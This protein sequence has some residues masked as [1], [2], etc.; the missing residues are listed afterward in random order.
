M[1]Q[2]E[3][4]STAPM[5]G[6]HNKSVELSAAKLGLL[7][8]LIGAAAIAL[9]PIF[10]RLSELGPSATGFH[11]L[12]LALPVLWLWAGLDSRHRNHGNTNSKNIMPTRK[13]W[14][15]VALTG[16]FFAGDIAVWHWSIRLTSVANAALLANFAPIFVALGA[17]VWLK[18]EISCK[19]LLA[20]VIALIGTVMVLG[21]SMNLSERHLLG[22]ALGI[23]TAVFY[24]LYI[25]SVKQVRR[26]IATGTLMFWSAIISA[27]AL[28]PIAV[29]SGEGLV[30]NSLFGWAVLGGLALISH[31][32]GQGL[33]TYALAHLPASFSSLTLLLQPVIAAFLAWIVLAEPLG[34]LQAAGGAVVLAGILLASRSSL[35]APNRQ[36]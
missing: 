26:T 2:S 33:I 6:E 1:M 28:L 34:G 9:A 30:A 17:A 21:A 35:S 19:F 7:A 5:A 10:V 12:F 16:L 29:I 36:P 25:L 13:E 31:C 4:S 14:P 20:L 3:K 32:G 11:R 8:L 15:L 22:D 18:E 27:A 24:A 23:L